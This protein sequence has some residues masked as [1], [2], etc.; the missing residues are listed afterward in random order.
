MAERI[1]RKP[2]ELAKQCTLAHAAIGGEPN[3]PDPPAAPI[4]MTLLT[5]SQNIMT[6]SSVINALDAQL[7]TA[8]QRLKGFVEDAHDDMVKVDQATDLLYGADGAQKINFGLPPK[9]TTDTATGEPDQVVIR[10]TA[11]GSHP[12]SIWVD[13]EY[14]TGAVYEVQWFTDA[15]LAQMVGSAT[16]TSSEMEVQGLEA[17]TQY[18]F[19]VRAVRGGNAG[20][21]S[22]QAT[23]VA[24]I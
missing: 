19:R 14:Q 9:K 3:W 4:A 22:D 10:T 11:D 20:P 8:R 2:D 24:N 12:A 6:E 16:V 1:S 15:T 18:W 7:R 23:R 17:G 5:R 13:W 21:W